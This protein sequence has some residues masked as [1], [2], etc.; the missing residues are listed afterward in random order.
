MGVSMTSLEVLMEKIEASVI[1][2]KGFS[3]IGIVDYGKG[4]KIE[5]AVV[6]KEAKQEILKILQNS[7]LY[8]SDISFIIRKKANFL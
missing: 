7:D 1:S 3:G 6:N 2:T 8:N 5:I 4:E